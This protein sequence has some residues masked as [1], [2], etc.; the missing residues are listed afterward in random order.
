MKSKMKAIAVIMAVVALAMA[1]CTK[2]RCNCGTVK[3]DGY[4][5]ETDCHWL[6]VENDCTSNRQ[7]FCVDQDV[8]YDYFPGDQICF[9]DRA[10]W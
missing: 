7:T 8:W 3:N 6:E 9:N 2:E 4:E 10:Q 1:G 5:F